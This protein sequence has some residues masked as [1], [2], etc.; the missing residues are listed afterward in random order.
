MAGGFGC[1][2]GRD[3]LALTQVTGASRS[4]KLRLIRP[5]RGC[6]F[7]AIAFDSDGIV[8]DDGC[9]HHSPR[10]EGGGHLGQA[11]LVQ[12]NTYG[13]LLTRKLL[14]PGLEDST[15]ATEA[16]GREVLVTQDQPANSGYAERDWVWEWDGRHLRPISSYASEDADQIL[17]IPW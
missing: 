7:R 9:N 8:T 1:P 2:S 10:N 12:Y 6:I 13:H 11:V 14:K 5:D 15:I 17:A 16:D 4:P 3:Y